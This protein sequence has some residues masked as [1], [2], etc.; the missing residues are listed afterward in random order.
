MSFRA[1]AAAYQQLLP[2]TNFGIQLV[3]G[4]PS[5]EIASAWEEMF[6]PAYLFQHLEA[7]QVETSNG[8]Q[9]AL[10]KQ[11]LLI[12]GSG[13]RLQLVNVFFI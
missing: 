6:L 11:T 12:Y 1:H 7:A 2:W 9:K 3:L 5:D 13:R 10:V 4:S 8:E